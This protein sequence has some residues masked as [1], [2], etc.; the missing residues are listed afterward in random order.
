MG[1][2]CFSTLQCRLSLQ[3]VLNNFA[4][5]AD[6]TRNLITAASKLSH[7]V[8]SDH[9]V[10]KQPL[11][12]KQVRILA[13]EDDETIFFGQLRRPSKFVKLYPGLRDGFLP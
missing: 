3:G 8:H 13:E 9:V 7:K 1:C 10:Q 5:D 2:P 4:A 12:L 6:R 11:K